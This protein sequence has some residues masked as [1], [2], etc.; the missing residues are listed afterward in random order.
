MPCQNGDLIG[1]GSS[2]VC[3]EERHIDYYTCSA[4]LQHVAAW[5]PVSQ[6]T[7]VVFGVA[8]KTAG[9]HPVRDGTD[10]RFF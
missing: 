5:P 7:S 2:S 9:Q 10:L 3:C 8:L 1:V 4:C 6:K